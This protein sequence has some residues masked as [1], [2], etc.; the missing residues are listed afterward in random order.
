MERGLRPAPRIG[1][2]ES[3]FEKRV[4]PLAPCLPHFRLW[5]PLFI[6]SDAQVSLSARF[7]LFDSLS[8]NSLESGEALSL[9][10]LC[11]FTFETEHYKIESYETFRVL[12]T[13]KY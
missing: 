10:P 7:S 8:K 13:K 9:P 12:R 3:W 4:V 1:A 2:N 6:Y 11:E 5:S